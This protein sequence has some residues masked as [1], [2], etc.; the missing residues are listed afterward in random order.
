MEIKKKVIKFSLFLALAILGYLFGFLSIWVN[1]KL[2]YNSTLIM[3]FSSLFLLFANTDANKLFFNYKNIEIVDEVRINK[4][5]SILKYLY[6]YF[7]SYPLIISAI[8]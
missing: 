6:L 4:Y 2:D 3:I 1:S 8:K 7:T 5:V